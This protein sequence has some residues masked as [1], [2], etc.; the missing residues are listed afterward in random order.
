[1]SSDDALEIEYRIDGRT[2]QATRIHADG[3]AEEL[4]DS[5]WQ[6]LAALDSAAM[7]RLR[8]VI[9]S[10]DFF[11]LPA[12]IEPPVPV[13]DGVRMTFAITLGGKSH[14]VTGQQGTSPAFCCA[15]VRCVKN[16]VRG[17]GAASKGSGAR[18]CFG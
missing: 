5:S 2:R 18:G 8:R 15:F 4:Q 10:V 7:R 11:D 13:R 12:T 17:R 1:M 16:P 14:T 9:E 6:P 3:S